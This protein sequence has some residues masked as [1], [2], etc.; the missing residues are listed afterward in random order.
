MGSNW[1]LRHIEN[2]KATL[3]KIS[4]LVLRRATRV[5]RLR[6]TVTLGAL[7][8][9]GTLENSIRVKAVKVYYQVND[10]H[11]VKLVKAGWPNGLIAEE[12]LEM[13]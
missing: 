9:S 5:A 3:E 10:A 13:L 7:L 8:G 12:V 11:G 6:L 1:G 2:T 4:V